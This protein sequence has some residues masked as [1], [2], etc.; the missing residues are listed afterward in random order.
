ML[1]AQHPEHNGR[2][3]LGTKQNWSLA[4]W[5]TSGTCLHPSIASYLHPPLSRTKTKSLFRHHEPKIIVN[6]C[7]C[8]GGYRKVFMAGAPM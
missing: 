7:P 3:A 5:A 4:A 8:G 6:F 1:R 2:K